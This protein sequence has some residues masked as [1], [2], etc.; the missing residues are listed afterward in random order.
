[1]LPTLGAQLGTQF[2]HKYFCKGLGAVLNTLT[3]LNPRLSLSN[4]PPQTLQRWICGLKEGPEQR[5]EEIAQL[6]KNNNLC[7]LNFRRRKAGGELVFV[8]QFLFSPQKEGD[9]CDCI[10]FVLALLPLRFP[11]HPQPR[12]VIFTSQFLKYVFHH[13]NFILS[14]AWLQKLKNAYCCP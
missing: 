7:F 11:S 4:E 10:N 12:Q 8:F 13:F 5:G 9:E 14:N 6:V 1:M 2:S 3:L